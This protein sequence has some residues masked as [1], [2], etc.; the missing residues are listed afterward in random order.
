[1][2]TTINRVPYSKTNKWE[3][4]DDGTVDLNFGNRKNNLTLQTFG[5]SN[6]TITS[7]F[8]TERSAIAIKRDTISSI[9]INTRTYPIWLVIAVLI[10][11]YSAFMVMPE[12]EKFEDCTKDNKNV[13]E[14]GEPI[15]NQDYDCSSYIPF[16]PQLT[17]FIGIA[18]C[19]AGYII[20]KRGKII[21]RVQSDADFRIQVSSK[22]IPSIRQMQE[23]VNA[24]ML[25][26]KVQKQKVHSPK[27]PMQSRNSP[28]VSPKVNRAH[29][30]PPSQ[31]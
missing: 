5:D 4:Y 30:Y 15:G 20:T 21:I 31:N 17:G 12:L 8:K 14:F 3:T 25:I 9:E 23:L 27:P 28:P 13:N 26:S 29:P 1:M 2:T 7:K 16:S 18:M 24:I 22:A 11:F 6:I 10:F 19:I